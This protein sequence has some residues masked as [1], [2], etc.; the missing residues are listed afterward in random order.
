MAKDVPSINAL[1]LLNFSVKPWEN[2]AGSEVTFASVSG[3]SREPV[4]RWGRESLG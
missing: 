4:S 2:T 3:R 1:G